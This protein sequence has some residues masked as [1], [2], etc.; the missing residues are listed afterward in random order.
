MDR[1]EG[2]DVSSPVPKGMKEHKLLPK[3]EKKEVYREV[4]G[5]GHG[6]RWMGGAWVPGAE[7][8]VIER[9]LRF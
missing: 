9:K 2:Q 3:M 4:R 1:T 6:G 5:P 7:T 8:P